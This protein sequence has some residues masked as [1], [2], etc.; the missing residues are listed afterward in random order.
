MRGADNGIMQEPKLH[1]WVAEDVPAKAFYPESPGRWVAEADWPPAGLS[2]KRL[3]LQPGKLEVEPGP[4]QPVTTTTPQTLGLKA[5][6]LMPWFLHGPAAELPGRSEEHT[7]ELQSLMRI[8]YAVFCLK[9]KILI[10]TH[11][12]KANYC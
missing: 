2:P 10:K 5:G 7:S 8:S 6:E 4:E 11:H 12:I 1:A 3:H 9:K